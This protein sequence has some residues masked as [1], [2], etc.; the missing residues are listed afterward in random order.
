[1]ANSGRIANYL[2]TERGVRATS[3]SNIVG[4]KG[5]VLQYQHAAAASWQKERHY[6]PLTAEVAKRG[7]PEKA[8]DCYWNIIILKFYH[9]NSFVRRGA[10]RQL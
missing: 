6:I 2:L 4:K 1:V 9:L 7:I 5:M 3:Y 10:S 8:D